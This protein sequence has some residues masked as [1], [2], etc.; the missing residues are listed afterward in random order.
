MSMPCRVH[1]AAAGALAVVLLILAASV[2]TPAEAA[3]SHALDAAPGGSPLLLAEK[4]APSRVWRYRLRVT[5]G[6]GAPDCG[7]KRRLLLVNGAFQPT[8]EVASGDTLEV[9]VANRISKDW[10]DVTGLGG[11]SIHWHGFSM[12]GQPW[13]DGTAW[14]AQ[15]PIPRGES[16]LY[17]FVVNEPPGTYFWHDHSAMNRGDGLQ[18]ALIVRPA[19]T[20]PRAK[21]PADEHTL[22]LSDWWDYTG[23][24]MAMRLNRP[25]DPT[26][27]TDKSGKWCWVGLPR[28]LLIN[29]R[30]AAP[31]CENVYAREVNKTMANGAAAKQA[32]LMN[33]NGCVAG[34]LGGPAAFPFCNVDAEET[35]KCK[36]SEVRLTPGATHTF[37]LINAATLV[38]TTVCF[39]GHDVTVVAADSKAVRPV[40]FS[41]CVDVNSGQRLDV[42]VTAN[43]APG[44]YWISVTSQ[45]RKGA[46]SAYGVMRYKGAPAGLPSAPIMQPEEGAKRRWDV[47]ATMSLRSDTAASGAVVPQKVDKRFVI[48][49]TQPLFP[50]GQLKWALDNVANADKPSCSN[51]LGDLQAN[52][53]LLTSLEKLTPASDDSNYWLG[54]QSL[55][56]DGGGVKVLDAAGPG[57]GALVEAKTLKAGKHVLS[58][59]LGETVEIVIVNNRA[60]AFGGEY[61]SSSP[62]TFPRNGREQ[63]PFHLHGYHFW[64]VGMG[65]GPWSQDAV[66]GYNVEDPALRDT[67][68]VLFQDAG[69]VGGWVALRFTASN[70]GVWPL[71]CHITPHAAMGQAINIIT[72]I[73]KVP[74]PPKNMP[75]CPSTCYYPMAQWT[76]PLTKAAFGDNKLLAPLQ[77]NGV[78]YGAKP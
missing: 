72:A 59:E 20:K 67:A 39:A 28:S 36:R 53:Q 2:P 63:H 37:R 40:K 48:Q 56:G 58:L 34:Q 71:H 11:I 69:D 22:F 18:G 47:N 24:A 25:F 68:T 77:A 26:K 78:P 75:Q 60:G 32:D 73:D 41:E 13:F 12:Q 9:L 29:G 45:Y 65:L 52:P 55:L 57:A 51:L 8:L 70:P 54:G 46:P 42:L 38:Y 7:G 5:A 16:F 61:N 30:G 19:G 1:A 33:P 76:L 6:R 15:C 62:L 10:P 4:A 3:A 17:S 50:T 66:A 23:A 49:S 35:K 64:L 21:P 74:P 43:Q 44:A 27:A 31:D 14:L